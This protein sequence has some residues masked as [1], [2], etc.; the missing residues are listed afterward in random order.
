[1]NDI[2]PGM[3]AKDVEAIRNYFAPDLLKRVAA[4][5]YNAVVSKKDGHTDVYLGA[6]GDDKYQCA[7]H[8]SVTKWKIDPGLVEYFKDPEI[9]EENEAWIQSTIN[10]E[11][12]RV[13]LQTAL[14]CMCFSS[15]PFLVRGVISLMEK[16]RGQP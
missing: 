5:Y 11:K 4:N 1:M 16:L 12:R 9:L 3:P 8:G 7:T 13:R 15:S 2:P 14:Y 10:K 6:L